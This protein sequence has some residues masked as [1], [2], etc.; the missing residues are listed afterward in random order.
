MTLDIL[1]VSTGTA[2]RLAP[3]EP[4]RAPLFALALL[5][6]AC[7]LASFAFACATP[8]AAFAVVAAAMLPLRR[9]LLVVAGAWLV[10]Q[11]IGFA[12]LGYPIDANTALW[13]LAIGAAALIA[14][15]ASAAVLQAVPRMA[16]LPA[17]GF[18]LAAAYSAY[19]LAMIAVT[20]LLGGE[21]A[22]E[23]AIVARLGLL[24]LFW[25]VGLVAACEVFRLLAAA[26]R[27]QALS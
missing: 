12:F 16:G 8:F 20:P 23:P 1:P 4:R 2:A 24:S 5:A 22:F 10:N 18:A 26:R 17:L 6:A 13:G 11:G 19:E 3:V 7:A 15:A 27:R 25:L 14:T 9:A 21:A